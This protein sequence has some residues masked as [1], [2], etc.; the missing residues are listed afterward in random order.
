MERELKGGV[1]MIENVN[2]EFKS[3]YS[4]KLYRTVIAF[5]NGAGGSLYIGVNDN[6]SVCRHA[7]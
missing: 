4:D 3:Q 5:A 6:G 2:S 7:H 1:G